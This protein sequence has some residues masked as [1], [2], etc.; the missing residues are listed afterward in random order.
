MLFGRIPLVCQ[1]EAALD[2]ILKFA[3]IKPN[4]KSRVI[5]RKGAQR[6]DCPKDVFQLDRSA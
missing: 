5:K 6:S 4:G 2:V 1:T 3:M